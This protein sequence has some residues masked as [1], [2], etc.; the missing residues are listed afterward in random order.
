MLRSKPAWVKACVEEGD[1]TF[2]G[3]PEESIAEWHQRLNLVR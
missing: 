2:D 3:Y 1:Q